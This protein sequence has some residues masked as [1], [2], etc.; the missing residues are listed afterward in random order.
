[1]SFPENQD[2]FIAVL[3]K[4]KSDWITLFITFL[5]FKNKLSINTRVMDSWEALKVATKSE[6]TGINNASYPHQGFRLQWVIKGM[7]TCLVPALSYC[8]TGFKCNEGEIGMISLS[9][10]TKQTAQNK[11]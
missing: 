3:K 5:V 1:M 6:G 8:S 10:N 4:D 11:R 2:K 9:K 7:R